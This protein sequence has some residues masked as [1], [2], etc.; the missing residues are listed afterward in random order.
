M[1]STPSN[2]CICGRNFQNAGALTKH[3]KT[4]C[5]GR[6]R[7]ADALE[8][9]K[10]VFQRKKRRTSPDPHPSEIHMIDEHRDAN[11][12]A[13]ASAGSSLDAVRLQPVSIFQ[14]HEQLRTSTTHRT[15]TSP[16]QIGELDA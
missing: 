1:N 3:E 16:F 7:L 13:S 10:E 6:K 11:S 9:A 15:I 5:K 2:I 4:C 14:L 12:D 8:R